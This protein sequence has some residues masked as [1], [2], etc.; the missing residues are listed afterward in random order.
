MG[1]RR[2]PQVLVWH[3]SVR[4]DVV[5][6]SYSELHW[7]A[8]RKRDVKEGQWDMAWSDTPASLFKLVPLHNVLPHQRLN[9]FPLMQYLCR[10]DLLASNINAMQRALQASQPEATFSFM[11]QTWIFPSELQKFWAAAAKHFRTGEEA[12]TPRSKKTRAKRLRLKAKCAR[13]KGKAHARAQQ[14]STDCSGSDSSSSEEEDELAPFTC[15]AKPQSGSQGKGIVLFQLDS[16]HTNMSATCRTRQLL[17]KWSN[18]RMVVQRFIENPL[19]IDGFKWDMRVYVLITNLEPLTVYLYDDGLARFCTE[20]YESPDSTNLDNDE[21]HLTNYSINSESDA[22]IDTDSDDSGSKRS[23]ASVLSSCLGQGSNQAWQSI[24][25]A[26]CQTLLAFVPKLKCA[27]DGHFGHLRQ[28]DISPP[29]GMPSSVCFEILGFDFIMD[30]GHTV[31]LLEINSAPS[32]ATETALD[33]RLK[34]ELLQETFELLAL[35]PKSKRVQKLHT[36][37]LRAAR[38]ENHLKRQQVLLQTKKANVG[39]R[40]GQS[41]SGDPSQKDAF[42]YS[43]KDLPNYSPAVGGAVHAVRALKEPQSPVSAAESTVEGSESTVEGSEDH[44]EDEDGTGDEDGETSDAEWSSD[45][46]SGTDV[47]ATATSKASDERSEEEVQD[48]RLMKGVGPYVSEHFVQ[49]LPN[50]LLPGHDAILAAAT[51]LNLPGGAPGKGVRP[52][53]LSGM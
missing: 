10:K 46:D 43:A 53:S 18:E 21:M 16:D 5:A 40:S 23:L 32:L 17:D 4:H 13:K 22:F 39:F 15:I 8:C 49:L 29:G 50:P 52:R 7:R 44:T 34:S 51:R 30:A 19:L 2:R 47:K 25:Q 48:D 27:Y 36:Q 37:K 1:R 26:I 9:H 42:I 24:A 33:E 45:E 20:A 11:P 28:P 3:V 31:H 41:H 35:D 14:R 38:Q 12:L 6:E